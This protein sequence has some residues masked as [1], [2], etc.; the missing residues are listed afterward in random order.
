MYNFT[1]AQRTHA[2]YRLALFHILIIISSNY[3]VQIP[4]TIF[5]FNTTWGAFTFPFV[6]LSTDLTIRIFG[7][8][9][10]RKIIFVVMM[11]AL[12]LSYLVSVLFLDGNWMGWESLNSFNLFVGRIALASFSAYLVGQLMDI[13]V[14]NRLRQNQYWWVAPS[15]AAII[16]NLV[17][18]LVFFSIAFYHSN[19][20][21]MAAHWTEIAMIDYSFKILICGLFFLPLYGVILNLLLRKLTELK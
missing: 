13:L 10:A 12:V 6:I 8:G 18:T 16:G 3:L 11:P 21:F 17:D 1:S 14:F 7:A 2:L 20:P 19:D 9:L 15:V 4:F 5:G